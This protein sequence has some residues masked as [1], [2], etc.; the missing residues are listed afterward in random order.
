[1]KI[2]HTVIV[3]PRL[4]EF[5]EPRGPVAM[6]NGKPIRS[7]D[8]GVA[9]EDQGVFGDMTVGRVRDYVVSQ[10]LRKDWLAGLLLIAAIVFIVSKLI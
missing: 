6:H 5:Q 1:M 2:S 9:H 8:G 10:S 4:A 7:L 3:N